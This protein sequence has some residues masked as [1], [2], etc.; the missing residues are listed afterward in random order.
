M[1]PDI[2][3]VPPSMYK[4][5]ERLLN[6]RDL[7]STRLGNYIQSQ[8]KNEKPCWRRDAHFLYWPTGKSTIYSFVRRESDEYGTTL[9][10][11]LPRAMRKRG[12]WV[13]RRWSG[14]YGET[15]YDP[16]IRKGQDDKR[17]CCSSKK[18]GSDVDKDRD[19]GGGL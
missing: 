8:Y 17:C 4:V 13:E 16:V 15:D 1:E 18:G 14:R 5:A 7:P 19:I 2:L 3:L 12:F 10:F 9:D 11:S 6:T